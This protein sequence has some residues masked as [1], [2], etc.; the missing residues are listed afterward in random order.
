MSSSLRL[1]WPIELV[2]L[3]TFI[4]VASGQVA[5]QEITDTVIKT[6]FVSLSSNGV[7]VSTFSTAFNA[8]PRVGVY[9]VEHLSKLCINL[10]SN[11]ITGNPL[12]PTVIPPQ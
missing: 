2:F 11:V 5:R 8:T 9:L 12:Q 7:A 6:G 3:Y 10:A 4:I 1:L